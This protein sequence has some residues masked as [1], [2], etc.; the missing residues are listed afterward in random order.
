MDV[1]LTQVVLGLRQFQLQSQRAHLID[2]HEIQVLVGKAIRRARTDRTRQGIAF[3]VW[4]WGV[5]SAMRL[6]CG[7][8]QP[9]SLAR[10]GQNLIATG[11]QANDPPDAKSCARLGTPP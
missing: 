8:E 11:K 9:P 1:V 6:L 2:A 3:R 7:H 4:G 5:G 10:C